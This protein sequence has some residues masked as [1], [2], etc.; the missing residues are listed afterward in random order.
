MSSLRQTCVKPATRLCQACVKDASNLRQTCVKPASILRQ[1]CVKPASSPLRHVAG[2]MKNESSITHVEIPVILI[3]VYTFLNSQCSIKI[4]KISKLSFL[5]LSL[6]LKLFY[7]WIH[8]CPAFLLGNLLAIQFRPICRTRLMMNNTNCW[9]FKYW[10]TTK[11][12]IFTI[13]HTTSGTC[14]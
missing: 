12:V 10:R 3:N 6:S 5:A 13:Q 7:S 4:S 9:M 2:F 14:A 8:L 1:V 11:I